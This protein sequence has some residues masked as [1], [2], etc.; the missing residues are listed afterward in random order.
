MVG[1][2]SIIVEGGFSMLATSMSDQ[3]CISDEY[4]TSSNPSCHNIFC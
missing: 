3:W 1:S 4:K 2:F